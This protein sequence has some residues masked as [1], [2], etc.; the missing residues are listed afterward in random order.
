[1]SNDSFRTTPPRKPPTPRLVLWAQSAALFCFGASI[2]LEFGQAQWHWPLF[3]RG[4]PILGL[5]IAGALLMAASLVLL[6]TS[7]NR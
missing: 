3:G 2:L 7:R 1:M 6:R 5:D 4:W